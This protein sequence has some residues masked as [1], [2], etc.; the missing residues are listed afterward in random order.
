MQFL[1][2]MFWGNTIADYLIALGIFLAAIIIVQ[3]IKKVLLYRL[4]K[5]SEEGEIRHNVIA[6]VLRKVIIPFLF[7]AGLYV[8]FN[9]LTFDESVDKVVEVIYIIIIA[10]FGI[11]LAITG[12]DYSIFKY[13]ESTRS[14]EDAIRVKPLVSFINLIIWVIGILFLL[15]NLGFEISSVIAGLG[16]SGIAIALAAQAVLGDLFSY[17][18]I[19]FDKPF[20]IGDFVIFDDKLGTIENIGIKSTK[21]RS[22]SG[23]QIIV[24]NS[25]LTNSRVHNYKRMEER[26]VVFNIGVVY[27]T[28]SEKLEKIPG[29]IREIIDN[30]ELTRFDR[31][32][33]KA[34][35]DFSLIFESVY[36]ILSS[37]Y[38]TFMDKQQAINLK[39]YKKFEAEGIEFA[40]PTQTIYVNGMQREN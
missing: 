33:F 4:E 26:R 17:F 16:I 19:Y 13:F 38:T 3:I 14:Q 9:T 37:D 11:R 24:S 23:E 27:Q 39:I 40:Y 25:N 29:M 30:E 32:H 7:L 21:I 34:Y 12:I 5:Q 28:P 31:S 22:L 8:A 15:D 36:Y 18:V 10:W 20:Q 2:E 35:G 6:R 1:K